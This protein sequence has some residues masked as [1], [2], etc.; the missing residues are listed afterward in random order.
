MDYIH[1][2]NLKKVYSKQDSKA[3][4]TKPVLT[5]Q[6]PCAET[7]TAVPVGRES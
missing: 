7:A 3:H 6:Q 1:V 2:R 5:K 4:K